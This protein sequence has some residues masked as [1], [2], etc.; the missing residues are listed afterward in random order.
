MAAIQAREAAMLMR[1]KIYS[2]SSIKK[3]LM[4]QKKLKIDAMLLD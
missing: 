3:L 1:L 4:L 2:S